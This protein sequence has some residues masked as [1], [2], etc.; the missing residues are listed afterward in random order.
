MW[1]TAAILASIVIKEIILTIIY[2]TRLFFISTLK[3][4]GHLLFY[5]CDTGCGSS[6]APVFK[7]VNEQVQLIALHRGYW[8]NR[9]FNFGTL[10]TKVIEHVKNGGSP[11]GKYGQVLT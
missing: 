3:H 4:L 9:N 7:V 8:E 2:I 10:I 5:A 6:G 1:L 11:T